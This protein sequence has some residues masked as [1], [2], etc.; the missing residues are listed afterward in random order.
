MSSVRIDKYIIHLQLRK[1]STSYVQSY[2]RTDFFLLIVYIGSYKVN[3]AHV[4]GIAFVTQIE[5]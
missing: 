1:M 5:E 4:L 2:A 3:C